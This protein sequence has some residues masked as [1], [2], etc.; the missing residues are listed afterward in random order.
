MRGT[1]VHKVGGEVVR[2]H[3][4]AVVDDGDVD[5]LSDV[6][7]LPH[8]GH[9]NRVLGHDVV[10]E[11]PL[12]RPQRVKDVELARGGCNQ[13]SDGGRHGGALAGQTSPKGREVGRREDRRIALDAHARFLPLERTDEP[14]MGS[15]GRGSFRVRCES[16]TSSSQE[17]VPLE[18]F[19]PLPVL[20]T[21]KGSRPHA[22]LIWR[23][24]CRRRPTFFSQP[25]LSCLGADQVMPLQFADLLDVFCAE[26]LRNLG[27]RPVCCVRVRLVEFEDVVDVSVVTPL[28]RLQ[29]VC[30]RGRYAGGSE[31]PRCSDRPCS[32]SGCC[33]RCV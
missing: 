2:V 14:R 6:A 11:M 9:I 4:E 30:V 16:E 27:R 1:G 20:Q 33:S 25:D 29:L 23:D 18:H 26:Y 24:G 17:V 22:V 28:G 12:F 13:A 3:V 8:S 15:G 21:R 7:L 31:E 32:D 10:D 5:S 19:V